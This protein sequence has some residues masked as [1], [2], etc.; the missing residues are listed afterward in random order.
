M[1]GPKVLIVDDEPQIRR[2]LRASLQAHD[3][4]VLEAENGKE[5][6]KACFGLK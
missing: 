1:S 3:Y 6:I 4:D 2:F 5:A